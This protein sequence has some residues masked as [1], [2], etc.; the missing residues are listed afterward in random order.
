VSIQPQEWWFLSTWAEKLF[1]CKQGKD[2]EP[3][4]HFLSSTLRVRKQVLFPWVLA[5]LDGEALSFTK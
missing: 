2:F 1:I 4:F 3:G 5:V